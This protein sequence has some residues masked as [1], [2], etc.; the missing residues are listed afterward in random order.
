MGVGGDEPDA[1]EGPGEDAAQEG[2]P[3]RLGLARANLA[4]EYLPVAALVDGDRDEELHQDDP[5]ALADILGHGVEPDVRVAL[6]VEAT[7]PEGADA[8]VELGAQ[9]AHI[10]RAVRSCSGSAP[11]TRRATCSTS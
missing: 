6:L 7:L 2:G 11:R 9:P 3:D 5:A 1:G 8:A 10:A 4:A